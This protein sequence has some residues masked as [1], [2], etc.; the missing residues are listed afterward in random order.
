MAARKAPRKERT[1][2]ADLD[3]LLVDTLVAEAL[4]WL[5]SRHRVE[6]RPE[7]AA[8]ARALRQS[9][10]R[11]QA[12]VLPRGVTVNA[13]LLDFAPR[14]KAVARLHA[15]SED[16]DLDACRD[17]GVRF[18]QPASASVRSNAEYLLA[19]MLLMSRR[20][21]ASSLRRGNPVAS[22]PRLG[23]ELYGSTVG[24]LGMSPNAHTLSG[25]LSALGC[26][27]IGYDPAIHR[28]APLW[29][30]LRVQPVS[31]SDL[32]AQAD[33]VSVQI[34]YASR[35]RGFI[36]DRLLESCKPGQIWV[37]TSRSAL[38][39]APAL[40]AALADGRIES[41]MLDGAEDGFASDDSPLAGARNLFLTPRLGSHTQ[42]ART[43]GSW[44]VAH[45]VHEALIQP[46]GGSVGDQIP[47]ATMAL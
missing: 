38:F 6:L 11:C 30:N 24:L 37:G 29:G 13:Q 15:G 9:L 33:Y 36:N 31:A 23:R 28:S 46:P 41:C 8:D 12:V 45:R 22:Q 2:T 4:S 14:L 21:V 5:E 20:G 25:L 39:D 3:I 26:R 35:Y 43:R 40:A 17:R 27:V 47:S 32:V 19:S 34:L 1:G 42:E 10:Y 44:Y 7:L 16:V 18:V